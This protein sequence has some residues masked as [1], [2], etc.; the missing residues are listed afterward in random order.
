MGRDAVF[1]IRDMAELC[2]AARQHLRFAQGVQARQATVHEHV[3]AAAG[4]F[5]ATGVVDVACVARYGVRYVHGRHAGSG[6]ALRCHA[7]CDLA[8][9]TA[10]GDRLADARH[11]GETRGKQLVGQVVERLAVRAA[12]EHMHLHH[13]AVGGCAV[14]LRGGDVCPRRT[15]R[16]L[17]L[18]GGG[19]A[20]QFQFAHLD[21][22]AR[23]EAHPVLTI[24]AM[25]FAAGLGHQRQ[26]G[27]LSVKR[28]QHV[29]LDRFRLRAGATERHMQLVA[30]Q[31]W[32][33]FHRNALPRH[34]A[35]QS[36]A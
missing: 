31:G 5:D 26:G 23:F 29:A 36:D 32:N 4:R 16:L 11:G 1:H 28:Q 6:C 19:D 7:H 30:L 22:A 20:L 25:H 24:R 33:P 12:A 9:G 14:R 21:V 18:D 17:P 3:R 13:A 8:L 10:R 15:A 27:Y 2:R 35:Q 34:Q